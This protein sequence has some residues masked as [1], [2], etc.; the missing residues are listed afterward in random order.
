[1]V[2]NIISRE[3][4]RKENLGW[5][6]QYAKLADTINVRDIVLGFE[7]DTIVAA[8]ITYFKNNGSPVGDDL[9]W[10]TTIGDDVGGVTC[11][12]IADERPNMAIPGSTIMIRMLDSCIRALATNG[13]RKLFIDAMKGGDQGF[14]ELG[15]QKWA[16]YREVWRNV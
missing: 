7:G 6:D 11:I 2:L 14:Q 12:C 13:M 8:A 1:M 4:G 3:S 5:Y 16:A 15:F 9:P 10:A